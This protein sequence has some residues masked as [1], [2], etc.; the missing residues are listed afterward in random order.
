M[1][2]KMPPL[3]AAEAFLVA[4]HA[5]S[6]R[7]AACELALSPSA[8]TRR[9]QQLEA[10]V[11]A[12]LFVRGAS[13]T[14]LST[15]GRAYLAAVGPA[16]ETI[17]AATLEV[18]RE[19]GERKLRIACSHSIA[20]EWLLPRLAN[21]QS[22]TGVELE[23]LVSRDPRTLREGEAE[24]GIW[25][26]V[27]TQQGLYSRT[28]ADMNAVPVC[29]KRLAD[30]REPPKTVAAFAQYCLVADRISS[31]I[32]PRWLELAGYSGEAP[33]MINH[34]ETHQMSSE[35]AASG[36]GIGLSLPLVTERYIHSRRLLACAPYKI[37]TG[38]RYCLHAP[39]PF[40]GLDRATQMAAEWICEEA[41]RSVQ[42]MERWWEQ[43]KLGQV[44]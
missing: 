34:F 24:L 12:E 13:Q 20:A 42:R 9:I 29:A 39:R 27:D 28:I 3:A 23:L 41:S 18:R 14:A 5:R 2:R 40:A 37:Q 33:R 6:F 26:V 22:D 4:A 32:W 44:N 43:V 1:I 10:F 30:G 35:A 19:H 17:R 11:G 16:L 21:F 36:M 38:A 25:G 7:A 8:F 31:W 15:A